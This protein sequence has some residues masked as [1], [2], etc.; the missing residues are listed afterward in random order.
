MKNSF[1]KIRS[2]SINKSRWTLNSS[3]F[4]CDHKL[5][6]FMLHTEGILKRHKGKKKKKSYEKTAIALKINESCTLAVI[7][8]VNSWFCANVLQLRHLGRKK[9]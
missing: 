2:S 1:N 5:I 6:Y 3:D 4:R 7:C 9:K 8:E